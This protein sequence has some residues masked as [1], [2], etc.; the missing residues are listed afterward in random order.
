MSEPARTATTPPERPEQTEID[1]V[2]ERRRL[3]P[4]ELAARVTPAERQR[5]Y[6]SFFFE[7]DRRRP[8]LNRFIILMILSATI[9]GLGLVNDSAAV[10]IG[11]MLIAPLMTPLLANSA[12]IVEGWPRRFGESL[13]IVLLGAALGILVGIVIAQAV[14]R[15]QSE[16]LLP[17][18]ILGRTEPNLVDLAIALAA[19]AAGGYVMVRSEAGSALPGV[20][21]A[22]ALVPPLATVGITLGIGRTDLASGALLLFAT[23]WLAIVFAAGVVFALAGFGAHRNVWGRLQGSLAGVALVALLFVL[24]VPLGLNAVQRWGDSNANRIATEILSEW[25]SALTLENL[26][27]DTTTKPTQVVVDLAGATA[28]VDTDVLADSLASRLEEPVVLKVRF[29]PEFIAG[30]LALDS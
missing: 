6:E 12:A 22:V 19:G 8:Y 15:I 14:P 28:P 25:D 30:E 11:A 2:R 24:A 18:E 3:D 16:M 26:I 20:G 23:N 7:G 21:I 4:I 27:V 1:A 29:R 13:L 10:V 9:A 5:V 17:A